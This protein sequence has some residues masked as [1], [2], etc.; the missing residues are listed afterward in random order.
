MSNVDASE[1]KET[2]VS[3][4]LKDLLAGATGGVA[5]VLIGQPFDIIKVRLQTTNQYP[6][7]LTAAKKIFVQE[8]ASAFYKGTLTPLIGIGACVSIQF[9]AFYEARRR[10]EAYNALKTPLKPDLSYTQ[11]YAA[12]AFAGLA[13]SVISGPIE[14]VRIRLQTQPHGHGKL[15][16]GPLDCVRK[17]CTR[18][19]IRNGLYRGEMVTILRE[20]Q[21]YGVWFLAF[22]YM[23]NADVSRNKIERHEISSSKV[24]LYGGLA[25]EALWLSC[26]P[27]DVVKS[28]MQCDDLGTGMRYKGMRNCFQQTYKVEGILGFWKGIGPTLLRAMPVSAGTFAVVEFTMRALSA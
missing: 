16:S 17:L 4:Q 26:Y 19:G 8:G 11:Y 27:F 15:Y 25:G 13:N 7:A 5:Q 9:G 1:V 28:K 20:A 23:M 18:A 14:H 3:R 6:N 24:A 10:L 21:A 2:A 22:E 12:G